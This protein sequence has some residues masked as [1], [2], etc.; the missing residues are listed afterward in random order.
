VIFTIGMTVVMALAAADIMAGRASI[1]SFVLVNA[2]LV[3]STS[4]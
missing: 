2:M 3:S 1:G 4:R